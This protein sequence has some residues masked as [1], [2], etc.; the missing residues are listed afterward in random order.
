MILALRMSHV[1][2]MRRRPSLVVAH[3]RSDRKNASGFLARI[4]MIPEKKPEGEQFQQSEVHWHALFHAS[5][6]G[7]KK[8]FFST[9]LFKVFE[10][11]NCTEE[12]FLC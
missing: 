9:I 11:E 6:Q 4:R 7:T 5:Q 12:R 10:N 8:P 2:F 1:I 3:G